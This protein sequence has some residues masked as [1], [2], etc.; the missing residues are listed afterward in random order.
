MNLSCI[1]WSLK[2][3]LIE[4]WLDCTT[5]L[6]I[7]KRMIYHCAREMWIRAFQINIIPDSNRFAT[8]I[9]VCSSFRHSMSCG[10]YTNVIASPVHPFIRS[11]A[12]QHIYNYPTAVDR[13]VNASRWKDTRQSDIESRRN[14]KQQKT[15][16]VGRAQKWCTCCIINFPKL[17]NSLRA[18]VSSSLGE[19][20]VRNK[21]KKVNI[22]CRRTHTRFFLRFACHIHFHMTA[23]AHTH[24]HTLRT[25]CL[26]P[27]ATHPDAQSNGGDPALIFHSQT[28]NIVNK[29]CCALCLSR[30]H[31]HTHVGACV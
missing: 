22:L 31:T 11:T 3:W 29:Y 6:C 16:T 28:V 2:L 9:S 14:S 18:G 23:N 17:Q 7:R 19:Q 26:C 15:N 10:S 27:D 13:K 25:S 21:V 20:H 30:A 5:D 12:H 4:Y 24:T 1:C 8:F